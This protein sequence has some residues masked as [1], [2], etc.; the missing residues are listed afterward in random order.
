VLGNERIV[1]FAKEITK[2]FETIKTSSLPE[3]IE[4]LIEDEVHQKGEFV[5][6]CVVTHN[7]IAR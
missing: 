7:S 2:S 5:I 3:L 1:C 4:Y 6:I